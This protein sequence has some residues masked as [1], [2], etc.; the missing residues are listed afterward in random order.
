ME[1]LKIGLRGRA[2]TVVDPQNVAAAMGSGALPVFATPALLGLMEKAA[3][4]AVQPCLAP[5]QAT[6]G[7]HIEL[8]HLAAS[9]LGAQV[10]AEATLEE[11]DRRRLRFS[12]RAFC[13]GE[14]IGRGVHDRFIVDAARF[15]AKAERK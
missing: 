1:E 4:E 11:I 3:W 13:G 5:G 10:W 8:D 15:M 2:E 6:V 7:T 12:V 9:P 14:E